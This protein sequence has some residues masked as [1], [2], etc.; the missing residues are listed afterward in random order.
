MNISIVNG[1]DGSGQHPSQSLLDMMT[2]YQEF[3]HFDGLKIAIAGDIAHS[4]VARSNAMLL[5]KLGAEVYFAGPEAWMAEDLK[6]YGTFLPIDELVEKVDVMMLLR[7]QNE[8]ISQDTAI[9]FEP[10]EYLQEYGLTFERA[11]RMQPTAI[12]MHP[13]PVNRGTE[14]ESSLVDGE[15]SRI[16]KQMTNGMYMRM[17]ILT[18]VLEAKGLI[19]GGLH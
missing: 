4:R 15:K 6:A 19:K 8:R 2:I 13:A 1:G 10:H 11:D 5:N 18:D 7:I 14:I 12:I 17:A 3:N 16:F 9:K